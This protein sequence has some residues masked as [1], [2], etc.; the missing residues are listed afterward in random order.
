MTLANNE[1]RIG[2]KHNN[3]TGRNANESMF[4]YDARRELRAT[5]R[6]ILPSNRKVEM[7]QGWNPN[8]AIKDMIRIISKCGNCKKRDIIVVERRDMEQTLFLFAQGDEI[9]KY[10]PSKV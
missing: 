5:K 2:A 3:K 8:S 4:A 9:L 7:E 10:S 6:F 1:R